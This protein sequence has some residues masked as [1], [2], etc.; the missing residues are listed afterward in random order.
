MKTVTIQA[1]DEIATGGRQEHSAQTGSG[2]VAA[3]QRAQRPLAERRG[4]EEWKESID[5]AWQS[6][7]ETLQQCVCGL[8]LKNQQLRMALMAAE[9]PER[10]RGNAK[11]F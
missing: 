6:H 2:A 7:L 3:Q 5:E 9:E 11:I 8:L 4:H 1:G 10:R